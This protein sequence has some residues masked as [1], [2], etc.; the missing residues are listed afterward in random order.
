MGTSA[1]LA[2]TT[3]VVALALLLAGCSTPSS[4][5][6]APTATTTPTATALAPAVPAYPT[7]T[8][9]AITKAA[10]DVMTANNIPGAIVLLQ[11]PDGRFEQPFGVADK[12]SGAPLTRD[13]Y[14]RI[15]SITKTMTVTVVLQ[16]VDQEK[17]GLD[18]PIRT[19]LP[20][21]PETWK[22]VTVRQLADMRSGIPSYTGTKQFDDE[23]FAD[24]QRQYM[25]TELLAMVEPLD[26]LFAPGT[27]FDYSNSNTVILGQ[28]IE[29]IT[30][31]SYASAMQGLFDAAGLN[32]TVYAEASSG[33]PEPHPRGYTNLTTDGGEADA[34]DWN[35]SWG[36]AAG[37][38]VSTIGDL[39]TWLGDLLDGSQVS[40]ESQRQRLDL[41][42]IPGNPPSTGYGLGIARTNGWIGHSGDLPGY[43]TTMYGREDGS[44]VIVI[45]STNSLVTPA[46]GTPV[47]PSAAIA[48]AV[49]AVV[50]PDSPFVFPH[51]GA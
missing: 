33:F 42:S 20:E 48:S 4:T 44:K 22:A 50:L 43:S 18:T 11:T 7:D 34:T 40:A 25:P 39:E 29:R 5:G 45:T 1:R 41:V 37:A 15:G 9:A 16:L 12:T 49:S 30:G 46:G 32:Q 21:L 2:R 28:L 17:V 14:M 19:Y 27:D 36:Q 10:T 23:F 35:A 6:S 51:V 13:E 26:L 38:G 8:V 3:T 24:H 31:A 47:P